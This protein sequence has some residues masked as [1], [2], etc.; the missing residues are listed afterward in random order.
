MDMKELVTVLIATKDALIIEQ[1]TILNA[2]PLAVRKRCSRNRHPHGGWA[3]PGRAKWSRAMRLAGCPIDYY[4][5]GSLP[6]PSTQM[7]LAFSHFL[8]AIDPQD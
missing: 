3:V 8:E 5:S 6:T 1:S 4:W 7:P 2:L